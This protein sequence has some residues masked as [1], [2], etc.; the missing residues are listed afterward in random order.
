MRIIITGGSGFIGKKLIAALK[1][2]YEVVV[3]SRRP[4]GQKVEGATVVEWDGKSAAGWGHLVE[5]AYAIIN[6]AGENLGGAYWSPAQ[7]GAIQESRTQ[8]GKAVMYAISAAQAKPKV[9]I[10]ASA[11]GYYGNQPQA[12]DE[13][14]PS[15]NDFLSEVCRN[16]ED[17]TKDAE[18]YGVRRVV[19]RTGVVIDPKGDALKKMMLPF[20]FFAGGPLGSGKQYFPWIHP[21][22]EI[23]AIKF[24]LEANSARGVFNLTAPKPL[25]NKEFA[26]VLGKVMWR[27]ALMPA[28]S[29]A[30]KL[31][32]GEMS[33]IVLEGQHAYPKRLLEM[34]YKFKFDNAESALKDLL[35]R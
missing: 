25:M 32:L 18:Q 34:G 2:S 3:L 16:W 30:L 33:M 23:G 14:A 4:Q 21:A 22:D 17:S 8:A 10:Q 13:T 6:L 20:Y 35:K 29:L 11:V 12:I 7:K 15:G 1:D 24:L 26:N 5:G 31:L 19:I 28:P 9:L 27:P